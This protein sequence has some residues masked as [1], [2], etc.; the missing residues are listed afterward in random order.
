MIEIH[1]FNFYL[2]EYLD[3]FFIP[4]YKMENDFEISLNDID[5][6]L[7]CILNVNAF[8]IPPLNQSEGY[9]CAT[10]EG[11]QIWNGRLRVLVKGKYARIVLENP[12]TNQIFAE[13]PLNDQNAVESVIDSCRYFVI[14][15]VNGKRH[16]FI[17][18]G[19]KER[20]ESFDFKLACEEAKKQIKEECN[21][22]NENI[23][24]QSTEKDYSLPEGTKISIGF[25]NIPQ[26]RKKRIIEG[27]SFKL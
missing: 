3:F 24:T 4:F 8:K 15:V 6:Q 16:A 14:R 21:I 20:N 2:V 19:M 27:S 18:I 25:S 12:S 13:C 10:W 5:R 1:S 17:G 9:K 26:A 23:Q 7:C 11:H 22:K